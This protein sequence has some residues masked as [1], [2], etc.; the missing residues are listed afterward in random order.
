MML[1]KLWVTLAPI[2]L[3]AAAMASD[4]LLFG[5]QPFGG[6][7]KNESR[8][9]E[10]Q[11]NHD[12]IDLRLS[13]DTDDNPLAVLLTFFDQSNSS[14]TLELKS[15]S[16]PNL[17]DTTVM[18]YTGTLLGGHAPGEGS[19]NLSP[20][21]QSFIGIEVRIPLS[22]GEPEVIRLNPIE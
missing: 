1:S 20:S 16:P 2:G 15:L 17:K 10:L 11:I 13:R 9:A 21:Q 22:R 12:R 8:T 19:G 18:D 7:F 3:I 5:E 4:D 6:F 14:T